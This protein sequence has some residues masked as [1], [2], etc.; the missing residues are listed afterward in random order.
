MRFA[1]RGRVPLGAITILGGP[2]KQ[3]KSTWGFDLA[4]RLS[5]GEA[6]GDLYGEPVASVLLSFEDHH[7][8]TVI[9]RLIAARADLARVHLLSPTVTGDLILLGLSGEILNLMLVTSPSK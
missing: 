3:G 1:L 7:G 2:P 5:R 9:P 8:A 4:A 6:D